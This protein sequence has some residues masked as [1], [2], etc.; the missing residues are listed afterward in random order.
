M[1]AAQPG[2]IASRS[3]RDMSLAV[4]L[5]RAVMALYYPGSKPDVKQID[6]FFAVVREHLEL[7]TL[8]RVGLRFLFQEV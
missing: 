6:A 3:G 1:A 2:S 7:T 5:G 4:E 8:Q